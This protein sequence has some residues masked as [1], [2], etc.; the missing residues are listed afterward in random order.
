WLALASVPILLCVG[1]GAVT[2][3]EWEK[4]PLSFG[5]YEPSRLGAGPEALTRPNDQ[6]LYFREGR[7][8]K[9][10]VTQ[11]GEARSLIINGRA[12]ASDTLGDM[13][14]QVMLAEIPLLLAEHADDV[15]VVGWG[16]GVTVGSVLRGGAKRVTAYE[17]SVDTYRTILATFHSVFAEVLAFKN[18]Y[19]DDWYLVGSRQP[20]VLDLAALDQRWAARGIQAESERVGVRRI[21]LLL[22]LLQLG[23]EGVRAFS[24]G[25]GIN[26]D[27]N[28]RVEC[29]APLDVVVAASGWGRAIFDA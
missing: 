11:K 27:D 22:S 23:P 15:L 26:T 5:P 8:A 20:L 19:G 3:P 28:M 17:I 1:L 4:K 7:T 9:I 14:T 10:A 12:N 2:L 6:L 24:Q 13:T 18:P 29:R 25:V 21:E 16:S